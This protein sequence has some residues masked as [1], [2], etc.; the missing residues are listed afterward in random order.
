MNG[1]YFLVDTAGGLCTM[2]LGDDAMGSDDSASEVSHSADDL[3]TEV[4]ELT[5]T[6]AS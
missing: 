1:L 4:E 5:A 3:T 2:A 6:L